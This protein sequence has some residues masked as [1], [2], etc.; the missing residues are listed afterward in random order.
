MEQSPEE[1][2]QNAEIDNS[3][4]AAST[5]SRRSYS[6]AVTRWLRRIHMY[7]A[8]FMFPWILLYGISGFLL[9]HPGVL[10]DHQI[11]NLDAGIFEGTSFDNLPKPDQV[12][13]KVLE[14][15]VERGGTSADEYRIV[16]PERARYRNDVVF[17]T[18]RE[19][20][21]YQLILHPTTR[22]GKLHI[23]PVEPKQETPLGSIRSLDSAGSIREELRN[24]AVDILNKLDIATDRVG[25]QRGP[26]VEFDITNGDETWTLVYNIGNRNIFAKPIDGFPGPRSVKMYLL[27]LH[28][29]HTYPKEANARTFWAFSVDIISIGMVFW[30]LSGILMWWQRKRIRL[31][32]MIFIAIGAILSCGMGYAMYQFFRG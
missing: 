3:N 28:F 4:D 12:A 30:G 11:K 19:G 17:N 15:L 27:R 21:Q 2:Y 7:L 23:R 5:S 25:I 22:S 32:G 24:G 10:S 26:L 16:N 13:R 6:R 1:K 14:A 29:A 18:T 31:R 20:K 8:L 9:N